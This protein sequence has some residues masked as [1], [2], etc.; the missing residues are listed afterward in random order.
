MK[1]NKTIW[2]LI[3]WFIWAVGKDIEIFFRYKTTTDFFVYE[4]LGVPPLFFIFA[5]LVLALN[6]ATLFFLIK[7]KAIGFRIAIIALCTAFLQNLITMVL[8]L[9]NIKGME[10]AYVISRESRGML[11]R[12]ESLAMM[13][14]PGMMGGMLFGVLLVYLGIGYFV[15]RNKGYFVGG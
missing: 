2:A 7:P 1:K 9:T 6:L 4:N 13:F 10:K 14:S 8:G 15:W 5:G 12:E 3:I 11:V